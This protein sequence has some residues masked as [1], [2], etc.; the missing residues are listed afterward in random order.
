M[1]KNKDF[2]PNNL[3]FKNYPNAITY[4]I[5]RIKVSEQFSG[6]FEGIF[7]DGKMN[8]EPF[9]LVFKSISIQLI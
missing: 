9:F 7:M 6:H 3:L 1:N 8:L 4:S 2:F 5:G